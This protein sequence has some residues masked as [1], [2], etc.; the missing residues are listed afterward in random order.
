MAWDRM[1]LGESTTLF[2][3]PMEHATWKP[4]DR[5]LLGQKET[6]EYLMYQ[7]ILELESREA[8]TCIKR[9]Y[10]HPRWLSGLAL[11]SAQGLILEIWDQVPGQAPCREPASPACVFASLS[12]SHE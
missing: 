9:S 3:A 11:P 6:V 1:G 12:V 10:G 7:K 8:E 4:W 2:I 5:G